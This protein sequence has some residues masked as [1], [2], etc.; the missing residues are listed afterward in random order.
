MR[1]L[2]L[3]VC[4]ASSL[5]SPS[6]AQEQ[7]APAK[8]IAVYDVDADAKAQIE[9]ALEQAKLK[10]TRV[11]I[12]WGANWCGWC[13]KLD[14]TMKS[15]PELASE[16][17]NEFEYVKINV[18]R[19]DVNMD[20]ATK[21]GADLK[22]NGIPYLT[23]LSADG[24]VISN[25]ETGSLEKDGGHDVSKVMDYLTAHRVERRDAKIVMDSAKARAAH[26]N[27]KIL[28]HFGA[29]WCSWCVKLK[30]WMNLPE[31]S[32][33]LTKDYIDVEIDTMRDEHA[34]DIHRSYNAYLDKPSGGGIPWMVI[35]DSAGANI[36]DSNASKG[37][38]GFPSAADEIAHF[39]AM[40]RSTRVNI[41]DDD[42]ATIERSLAVPQK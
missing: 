35:T 16:T 11:L 2:I 19:F 39:M 13:V 8:K 33:I 9:R 28:L 38:I 15:A 3:A 30:R 23:V 1:N 17:R 5:I 31:I 7:P 18:G 24:E 42:L 29:P 41:T 14:G 40:L 27:K 12:Q 22:G 36:A 25:T 37:N 32:A 10:R 26:E 20:L 34:G 6:F 21:Y 4:L